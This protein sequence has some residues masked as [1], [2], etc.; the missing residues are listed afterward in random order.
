MMRLDREWPRRGCTIAALYLTTITGKLQRRHIGAEQQDGILRFVPR[1][2]AEDGDDSMNE[3]T[4][5][6]THSSSARA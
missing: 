4:E 5:A 6:W 1:A 3:L 2:D